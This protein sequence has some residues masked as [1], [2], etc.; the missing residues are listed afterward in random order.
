MVEFGEDIPE[1][2]ARSWV[3]VYDV[4]EEDVKEMVLG[5]LLSGSNEEFCCDEEQIALLDAQMTLPR[6]FLVR[7]PSCLTNFV[8]L[9]CD[10]TC[11]PNQADF[12][13]VTA[14]TNDSYLV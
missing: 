2:S 11:S 13:R 8:Q 1:E 6:Q 9:W 10:F 5:W 4:S 12:I 14:S 7:C 3:M